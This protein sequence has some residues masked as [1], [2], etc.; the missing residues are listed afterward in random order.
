MR[1]ELAVMKGT[2]DRFVEFATKD[3]AEQL[4]GEKE[5]VAWFDPVCAIGRQSTSPALRNVH[6]GEVRVFE[7]S[8]GSTLK[9]PISAPRCWGSRAT[10]RS[11]SALC[12]TGDRR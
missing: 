12:E 4:D 3:S 9:Q 5:I 2:L 6:V 8:L 1:V 11:V 7:S 10:S